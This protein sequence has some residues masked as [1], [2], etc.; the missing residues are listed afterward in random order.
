[1]TMTVAMPMIL[2]WMLND[3]D[4]DV[5]AFIIYNSWRGCQI[6]FAKVE[7][8]STWHDMKWRWSNSSKRNGNAQQQNRIASSS[9][10]LLPLQSFDYVEAHGLWWMNVVKH[11]PHHA[12]LAT[13]RH[14]ST[15]SF[16]FCLEYECET[17][18]NKICIFHSTFCLKF[19]YVCSLATIEIV[20][21]TIYNKY[22]MYMYHQRFMIKIICECIK[23]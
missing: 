7:M 19:I 12:S 4:V 20:N 5:A 8:T 17:N 15:R 18:Y 22:N 11:C 9:S 23:F 6:Q 21:S 3:D 16:A 14:H 2:M 10:Q 13:P 1:M